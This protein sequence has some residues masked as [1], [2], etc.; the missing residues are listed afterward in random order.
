MDE[1]E[2]FTEAIAYLRNKITEE[3]PYAKKEVVDEILDN[4][5]G[6]KQWENR[7]PKNMPKLFKAFLHHA[8]NRQSMPNTIGNIENLSEV[9]FHF[10]HVKVN[11][12]YTKWERIFE[13]IYKNHPSIAVQMDEAKK[14][15]EG[16]RVGVS[17]WE[18][19]CKSIIS[20]AEFLSP[21]KTLDEFRD[22]V[23]SFI[24]N[25]H[26]KH[27]LPLVFEKE[28]H[29]YGFALACDFLKENICRD[30]V[31]PDTHLNDI[32]REL[33]ITPKNN[34]DNYQIFKDVMTYCEL[35]GEE[36][37]VVDKVFWLIGSGNFYLS[38]IRIHSSKNEFIK[39][40]QSNNHC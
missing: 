28:I 5:L 29:G 22:F 9:L 23:K 31:K 11:N 26:T 13:A 27:T 34:K 14:R 6:C 17:H 24:I 21:Y 15:K 16:K 20:I 7:K 30:F 32:A 10:D 38:E 12:Q 19:Y 35:I 1:K 37:Y 25:K 33:N 36:P 39:Q 18:S 40:V 2:Y 4:H 3:I 8:K